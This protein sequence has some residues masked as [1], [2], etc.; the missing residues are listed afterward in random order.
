MIYAMV[1][2]CTGITFMI[3]GHG[4]CHGLESKTVI[5][6]FQETFILMYFIRDR[7]RD[8]DRNR[9]RDRDINKP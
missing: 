9:N 2:H 4:L 7:D 3:F 5:S 8:R 6:C 1:H